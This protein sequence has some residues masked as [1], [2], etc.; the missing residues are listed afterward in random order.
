TIDERHGLG[1]VPPATIDVDT[2]GAVEVRDGDPALG[3]H[4]DASVGGGNE[5]VVEDDGAAGPSAHRAVHHAVGA[6]DAMPD[7]HPVMS[8]QHFDEDQGCHR[9]APRYAR[10]KASP[11]SGVTPVRVRLDTKPRR[12]PFLLTTRTLRS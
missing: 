4:A 8:V 6:V 1:T 11:R 7:P 9:I 3:V 12:E 10:A 2:V 5:R